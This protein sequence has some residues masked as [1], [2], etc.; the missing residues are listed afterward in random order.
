MRRNLIVGALMALGSADAHAAPTVLTCQ[1]ARK[2]Y[3]LE[4]DVARRTVIGKVD[5]ATTNYPVAAV[6][7]KFD[8][9]GIYGTTTEGGPT[10]LLTLGPTNSMNFY[11]KGKLIRSQKCK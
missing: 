5:D 2:S 8:G 10:W 7:K 3:V 4:V 11:A 1:D 9:Y 6:Q